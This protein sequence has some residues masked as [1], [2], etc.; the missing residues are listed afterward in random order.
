MQNLTGQRVVLALITIGF[1][2]GAPWLTSE[3]LCGN[4][5]PL[6]SLVGAGLLLLFIYGLGDRCWMIIPFC[7]PI[8]GNLN[9]LP[10]NFSI[11]EL[12][13]ISLFCYLL[14]RAI[15]GLDMAWK[16]GPAAIWIPLSGVL[17]VLLIHWIS[18]GDIGIKLLGG[19][20]WGGR[21]Y[22]Q[23][24]I[25][26]LSI[27]LL[28]SFPAMRWNDLQKVPFLFFLGSFV[29]IFPDALSTYFPATAPY[30]WKLY[31][32]VNLTEYGLALAGSF[33][34]EVGITRIGNL[35]KV[36][37]AISLVILCYVPAYTWLHPTRLWALP[38]V[39]LGGLACALSGFRNTVLR[40]FLSLFAGLFCTIRMKALLLLPV[41]VG[42]ALAIGLTQGSVFKY[43]LSLQ[44][45]LSF[46]PGNWDT[47]AVR[48]ASGSSEWRTQIK[49]LFYTEYFPKN[50]ILGTGYHYD[51][52]LAKRDTDAYLSIAA[53]QAQAGDQFADVR[54][55]VDQKMPHDGPVHALLV[56]GVLGTTFFVAFC[57]ALIIFCYRSI[58]RTPP[59]QTSPIQIWAAALLLPNV[60]GFFLVFGE[61]TS[62][63]FQAIPVVMLLYRSDR[64]RAL[65]QARP[66]SELV[67]GGALNSAEPAWPA[68]P[69]H[70]HHRQPPVH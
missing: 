49:T 8:E 3:T 16:L 2:V 64:L 20:G 15:F 56:T 34:G 40:Y 45:A 18:S 67:N 41:C 24:F 35:G 42:A 63:F 50:P 6:L 25:A 10:L 47:K 44:R 32:G 36:G 48:E 54:H 52:E 70:W 27:P 38:L 65:T 17:A 31:S 53:R 7:L 59:H 33:R 62:F 55:Y 23:I 13:I 21:K 28:A 37:S 29:D 5:T 51:P 26:A 19:T 9:F 46:T 30:L 43:P 68:P 39:L 69:A 60:F 22:F 57:G 14:L 58:L 66:A 61:Y 12:A 4:T 11:Q 1:F